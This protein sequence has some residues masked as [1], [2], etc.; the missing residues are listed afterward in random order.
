MRA[1]ADMLAE[2][3]FNGQLIRQMQ[4]LLTARPYS[5]PP[6]QSPTA[7]SAAASYS[8]SP[9]PSHSPDLQLLQL[10]IYSCDSIL[11]TFHERVSLPQPLPANAAAAAVQRDVGH[12]SRLGRSLMSMAGN[13]IR[14]AEVEHGPNAI[15]AP[16]MI[17]VPFDLPHWCTK[18][19]PNRCIYVLMVIIMVRSSAARSG[20]Q[21]RC[22]GPGHHRR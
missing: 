4:V 15:S 3:Q 19:P 18:D 13:A 6:P 17:S 16:V 21:G 9:A 8:P 7:A 5:C 10:S 12:L 22:R 20:R 1:N 11:A 2:M 14:I